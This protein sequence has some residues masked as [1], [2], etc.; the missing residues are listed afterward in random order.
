MAESI[1]PSDKW[2]E[3][4]TAGLL[5]SEQVSAISR[6][7]REHA[8][9]EFQSAEQSGGT[10][11]RSS[12]FSTAV[13][14]AVGYLGGLLALVGLIALLA[15]VWDDV[16]L[17][18][19][20]GITVGAALLLGVA[21]AF[22]TEDR[23]AA[24]TRLRAVLWTLSTAATGI[25]V[26]IGV[27]EGFPSLEVRT[28]VLASA[29]AVL[30]QSGAV[31]AGR[32]RPLQLAVHLAA[33]PVVTGTAVGHVLNDTGRGAAIWVTG[34]VVL[35]LGITKV[36]IA[37]IGWVVIGAVTTVVG[38]AFL[39]SVFE[40]TGLLFVL[41]T[42]IAI[43]A[44]AVVP[45]LVPGA[46]EG[47]GVRRALGIIGAVVTV[48][49]GPTAIGYFADRGGLATGLVVWVS[50]AILLAVGVRRLLRLPKM[51]EILGAALMV[52]GAAVIGV[53]F[54]AVAILLGLITAVGL[55]VLGIFPD[56]V[57]ASV[58]GS[59]G[60]LI[61]VPWGIGHFF[62]GEGR[63]PLLIFVTGMLILAIAVLMARRLPLLTQGAKK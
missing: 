36:A 9:S 37:R 29:T 13:P 35:W 59:L 40:F 5:T 38:A 14:E 44:L 15:R 58:A 3:W 57:L 20:L 62:P 39:A 12:H 30:I 16:A 50:G 55:L 26:G 45:G 52:L 21:G 7:E 23:G 63:V 60:L 28:V 18:A 42:G 8:L 27:G 48:Q 51:W 10:A 25:A 54:T 49:S 4:V 41:A 19:R 61:N 11:R 24:L 43:L 46:D 53:Q 47:A 56:R 1:S 2:Q 17:W 32:D 33:W 22:L 34:A 31:W 6:Y